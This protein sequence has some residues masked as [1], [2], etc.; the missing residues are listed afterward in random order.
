MACERSGVR[1]PSGPPA[2][3]VASAGGHSLIPMLKIMCVFYRFLARGRILFAIFLLFVVLGSVLQSVTPYF[4]KLF[5]DELPSLK[6]MV[7]INILIIY[8]LVRV[9]GLIL[10]MISYT[11]G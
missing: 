8:I 2:F 6:Y 4:Y 11:F 10:S 3:A 7:L 5:V 9:G 1:A